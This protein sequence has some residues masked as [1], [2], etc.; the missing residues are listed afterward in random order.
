MAGKTH[1]KHYGLAVAAIAVATGFELALW[2]WV[3]PSL[4]P[5]FTA[6]VVVTAMFGGL[7]PAILATFLSFI[8]SAFF[9]LP[10]SYSFDIGGD[11]LHRLIISAA[12]AVMVSSVAAAKRQAEEKAESAR[13]EAERANRAKDD[14]LAMVSHELRNP[15]A[16]V[17]MASA[18]IVSD[19]SL[20]G[21]VRENAAVIRRNVAMQTRLIDDLLDSCRIQSGK[22]ELRRDSVNLR[23]VFADAAQMV[24]DEASA[25][26]ID[27]ILPAAEDELPAE[28][29][30][31]HTRLCQ[32]F[33][34]LLRNA[35]KFTPVGG[36]VTIRSQTQGGWVRTE[37][38]D[39][40]IGIAPEL[41]PHLFVA[42][43][44]GG[45][46]VTRR[47]GGLGLGLWIARGIV[48]G[49][50]GSIAASSEGP[51]RGAT[52]TVELPIMSESPPLAGGG[53]VDVSSEDD[54]RSHATHAAVP[55]SKLSPLPNAVP[56]R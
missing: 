3:A 17:A 20:P 41:L 55:P 43:E 9:L 47:F 26:R 38:N 54:P 56:G 28:L 42:F 18:L 11:D 46:R 36:R 13:L 49:H 21:T 19:Q 24:R 5:L 29:L 4:S 22:L 27:L 6:A 12:V 1:W 8:V 37:V 16:P 25:K 52:F 40:G 15:L 51:H 34:N 53:G 14:F 10:P 33:C 23:H 35:V 30:G 32:V 31:D 39:T 7:G 50:G 2:P 44:Q 45:S 48:E